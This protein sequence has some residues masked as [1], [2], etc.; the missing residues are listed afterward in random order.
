MLFKSVCPTSFRCASTVTTKIWNL[1]Y[2]RVT[3]MS[4]RKIRGKTQENFIAKL[5][6]AKVNFTRKTDIVLIAL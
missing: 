6:N 3:A 2:K 1:C 4:S 5:V